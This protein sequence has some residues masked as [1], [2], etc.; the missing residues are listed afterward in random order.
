M[1]QKI[2]EW[3][4]KNLNVCISPIIRDTLLI[5]DAE[6]GVKWISPKL[7]LEFSM[8]NLHNE[9]TASPDYGGSLGTRHANTNDVIIIDTLFITSSTTSNDISSQKYVWLCYL[10]QFE[11]FSRIVKCMASEIIK[12]MKDK[13]GNS[14]VSENIN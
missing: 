12:K 3:I 9:I 13:V 8:R 11:V 5:T 7:L 10:Q 1:R 14:R 4:M 2:F 6:S